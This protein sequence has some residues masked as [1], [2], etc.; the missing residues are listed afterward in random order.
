MRNYKERIMRFVKKL[1]GGCWQ[2]Q[3]NM[4]T[5]GYGRFGYNGKVIKAHRASWLIFKGEIGYSHVLHV[6]DNKGCINPRHLKLGTHKQ[7][8]HDKYLIHD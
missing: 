8:V 6:C 5:D 3:G 4:N 7:N 1:D 2:W